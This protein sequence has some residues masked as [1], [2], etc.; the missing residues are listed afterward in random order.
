M[1]CPILIFN[2]DMYIRRDTNFLVPHFWEVFSHLFLFFR[3]F[4]SIFWFRKWKLTYFFFCFVV[5]LSIGNVATYI[6]VFFDFILASE[7]FDHIYICTML[8]CI[9]FIFLSILCSVPK[10]PMP[11]FYHVFIIS[12]NIFIAVVFFT[13]TIHCHPLSLCF[14]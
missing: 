1:F 13:F 14:I 5:F 7:H 11:P 8:R 10:H 3:N 9:T 4:Y 2:F 6:S 12:Y